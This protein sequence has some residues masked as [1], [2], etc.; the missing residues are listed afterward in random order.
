M[1]RDGQGGLKYLSPCPGD[2]ACHF[3]SMLLISEDGVV[4]PGVV[5]GACTIDAGIISRQP[6]GMATSLASN[7]RKAPSPEQAGIGTE[8]EGWRDAV[9]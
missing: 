8:P 3:T 6:R 4:K 1:I 2:E 9:D 5:N 7:R